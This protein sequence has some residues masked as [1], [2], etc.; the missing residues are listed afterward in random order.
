MLLT[1]LILSPLLDDRPPVEISAFVDADEL[2]VGEEY[3]FLLTVAFPEAVTASKAGAPA[4]FLQIDVPPSVK[5]TGRYVETYRDLARNEFLQEPYERLLADEETAIPFELVAA[6]AADERIAFSVI[7]YVSAENEEDAYFLRRRFE[8]PVKGLADAVEVASTTS[9][10]GT[11]EALLQI[12]D[13]AAPFTLPLA[14][15]TKL[16]LAEHLGKKN[17][18]VTTYRAHW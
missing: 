10:W 18:I 8:L 12:G 15:G 13:K 4:P 1:A 9:S 16:D 7:A 6:P 11:D 5:L 17:V 3:E 14:D 2:A